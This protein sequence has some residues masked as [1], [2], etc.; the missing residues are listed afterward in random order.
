M[1]GEELLGLSVM[2]SRSKLNMM[3]LGPQPISTQ[4]LASLGLAKKLLVNRL[5]LI[6]E[7]LSYLAAS[8][9]GD[10]M[11]NPVQFKVSQHSVEL[12]TCATA[13]SSG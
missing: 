2:V 12:S 10:A 8:L 5:V 4:V 1:G 3:L 6:E 11:Q 9:D 7:A 13:D